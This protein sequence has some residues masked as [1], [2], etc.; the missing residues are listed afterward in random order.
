MIDDDKIKRDS[1]TRD[2]YVHAGP[3]LESPRKDSL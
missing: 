1:G 2:K 3:E